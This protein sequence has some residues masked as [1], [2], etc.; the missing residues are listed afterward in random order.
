[1]LPEYGW[2]FY[3]LKITYWTGE[4]KYGEI[5]MNDVIKR[6]IMEDLPTVIKHWLTRVNGN[7]P[8]DITLYFCGDNIIVVLVNGFLNNLLVSE[9]AEYEAV[10]DSIKMFYYKLIKA[11]IP[12][13][14]QMFKNKY[15][16][17]VKSVFFDFDV[18]FN[19]AVFVVRYSGISE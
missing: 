13:A 18:N 8:N 12:L 4:K 7:T 3:L 11:K 14:E 16:L 19:E 1:M 5:N 10:I 2:L 6:R 9:C 17:H 15:N